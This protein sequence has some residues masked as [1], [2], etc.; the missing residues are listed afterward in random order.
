MIYN[1]SSN[2]YTRF[3]TPAL[4]RERYSQKVYDENKDIIEEIKG[5]H[6]Y[7]NSMNVHEHETFQLWATKELMRVGHSQASAAAL[8]RS[9]TAPKNVKVRVTASAV[10][11]HKRRPT[12]TERPHPKTMLKTMIREA[13]TGKMGLRAKQAAQ[14]LV[15]QKRAFIVASI[16]AQQ[17]AKEF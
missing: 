16:K 12:F 1:T 3:L 14:R 13:M 17:E 15:D 7:P 5:W 9:W 2:Y 10:V 11:P 6:R 4:K 8:L